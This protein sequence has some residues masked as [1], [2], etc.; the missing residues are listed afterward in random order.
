[1]KRSK[2]TDKPAGKIALLG[3]LAALAVALSWLESVLP[4]L[5]VPG[6]KWGLSNL[7]T[8]TALSGMGWPAGLA[9]TLVK[10]GFALLRGGTAALMSLAGGVC[11][12]PVMALLWRK[13]RPA[14]GFLGIGIA[15][16][17]AHNA[18]QL[19]MAMALVD[20][21]LWRYAPVLL[22]MAIAAGSVT[23]LVMRVVWPAL[24]RIL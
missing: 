10:A 7:A 3:I 2:I 11:S 21:G 15:G 23:G 16:A 19:L 4:A 17:A 22:V 20:A 24:K 8:M 18:G 13:G 6:A 5:P 14:A 1:M 12:L 9:I